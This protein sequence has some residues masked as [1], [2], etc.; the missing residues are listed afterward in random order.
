[1]IYQDW[2]RYAANALIESDSPK[3]DAEILLCH[4]TGKNRAY[5]LAFGE[6]AQL[7]SEQ[8]EQLTAL[9]ARRQAG[10]PIAYLLG[11]KEFWSLP[12]Y[13]SPATLIPRP[14]TECLVE[15]ALEY[16]AKDTPVKVLDLGTGTGAIALAIASERPHAQV[17][18][19]DKQ[20]Q[21]VALATRNAER[22]HIT[23]A[24]FLQS[25]WFS[26]LVGQQFE[27]ILSNPPYI[28]VDDPHLQQGDVRFEPLSAL[29]ANDQ[30]LA[31]IAH[32]IRESRWFLVNNGAL[33]I[34]HGWQ[35]AEAV[36]HLFTKYGYSQPQ[37]ARD[38]GG[39]ERLTFAFWVN[40]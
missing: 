35:Q 12:L 3:R 21:A 33:L 27:M 39:N 26:A 29:V 20:A 1:M 40:L 32:I 10:E 28:D 13:V 37:T 23:N 4:V 25:D 8:L 14:D 24:R 31:D 18:G 7:S 6:E 22:N 15:T 2:L 19:V 16:L 9:L 17:I 36:Q 11:E 34:E 38:F 30:G 5:L